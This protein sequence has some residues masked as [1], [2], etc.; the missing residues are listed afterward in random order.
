MIGSEILQDGGG[1]PASINNQHLKTL[2][3]I[4]LRQRVKEMSQIGCQYFRYIGKSSIDNWFAHE[5]SEIQRVR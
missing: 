4:N 1:R 5:Q 3:E 2:V